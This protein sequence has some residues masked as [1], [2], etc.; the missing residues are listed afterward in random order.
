MSW[1]R[2]KG[3]N[4]KLKKQDGCKEGKNEKIEEKREEDIIT[5]TSFEAQ[6][7]KEGR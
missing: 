1:E 4:E 7:L 2:G 5:D 6:G 3:K